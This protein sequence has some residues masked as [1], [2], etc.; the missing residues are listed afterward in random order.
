[1]LRRTRAPG[2]L[3]N[4]ATR[5]PDAARFYIK[6]TQLKPDDAEGQLGLAEAFF[7]M[8]S[9][10]KAQEAAEKA[11]AIDST[12]TRVRL[13]LAR[14][15]FLTNDMKRSERFFASVPDTGRYEP[16]RLGEVGPDRHQPEEAGTGRHSPGDRPL[17]KD[18]DVGR[19]LLGERQ[20]LPQPSEARLCRDILLTSRW[21]WPQTRPR[22]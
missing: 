21:P 6:Y 1:M 19:C 10:R 14:T 13:L 12:D 15:T 17:A 9:S 2:R 22:P 4:L 16:G 3:Y 18:S 8:G 7:K 20:D 5:Y 11:Y